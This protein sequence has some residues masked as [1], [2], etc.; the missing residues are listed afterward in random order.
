M[1]VE[2]ILE[3]LKSI[4]E[5]G[6][7]QSSCKRNQIEPSKYNQQPKGITKSQQALL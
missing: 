1:S 7:H 6:L 4:R 3:V 5:N 2:D